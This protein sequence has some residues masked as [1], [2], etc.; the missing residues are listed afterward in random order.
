M[1][2]KGHF[3][4]KYPFASA[5]SRC[6]PNARNVQC[7]GQRPPPNSLPFD[8]YSTWLIFS[9]VDYVSSVAEESE[10]DSSWNFSLSMRHTYLLIL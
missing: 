10:S 7:A 2:G 1:T 5:G 8:V 6:L 9:Y 4:F 3:V